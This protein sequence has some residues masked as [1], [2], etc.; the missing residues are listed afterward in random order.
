M[1]GD[2]SEEGGWGALAG[3]SHICSTITTVML[4]LHVATIS[5]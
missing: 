5:V 3:Q 1:K 2:G 4:S